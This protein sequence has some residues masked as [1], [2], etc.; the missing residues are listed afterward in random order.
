MLSNTSLFAFEP[1]KKMV[2]LKSL[3]LITLLSEAYS[4]FV[5]QYAQALRLSACSLV[6][7]SSIILFTPSQKKKITV[8]FTANN[9]SRGLILQKSGLAG[10]TCV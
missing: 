4:K 7:D 9:A 1:K 2:W 3:M 5:L 6:F 8:S 10:A